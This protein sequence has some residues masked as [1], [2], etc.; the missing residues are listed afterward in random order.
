ME[1]A[2]YNQ[3][4]DGLVAKW[5]E[6]LKIARTHGEYSEFNGVRTTVYSAKYCLEAYEHYKTLPRRARVMV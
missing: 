6:A 3:E 5:R 4:M 2:R 1:E